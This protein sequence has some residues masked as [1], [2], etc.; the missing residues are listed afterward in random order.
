MR[1]RPT[2]SETC[3]FCGRS[4]TQRYSIGKARRDRPKFCSRAC[5]TA[6]RRVG[7]GERAAT[8]FWAKVRRGAP[9]ECWP[10]TGR[11]D[12]KG[13]GRCGRHDLAHREAFRLANG[14]PASM[15]VCHS[16][17]NPPCCNP[18]HLWEGS[19]LENVRD[20][21]SKGRRGEIRPAKG[22][23]AS[24]SKLT[25]VAVLAIFNSPCSA[26]ELAAQHGVSATAIRYIKSG[27]NWAHLTGGA[28]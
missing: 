23:A 19:Q 20:M 14:R 9:N 16:C 27:R 5:D 10:W 15:N 8:R 4:F 26:R 24:K 25:E 1:N 11:R 21:V 18:A 28:E 2:R 17:D 13:Y 12:P 22:T 7:A 6:H 3:A